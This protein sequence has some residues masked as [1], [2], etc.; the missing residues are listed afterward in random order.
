MQFCSRR[1][2][3]EH[4]DRRPPDRLLA[5][6]PCSRD[7]VWDPVYSLCLPETSAYVLGPAGIEQTLQP[8]THQRG[9]RPFAGEALLLDGQLFS[10]LLP[11]DLRVIAMP[12]RFAPGPY[13]RAYQEAFNAAHMRFRA[14]K[15]ATAAK[16][17]AIIVSTAR[18]CRH[19]R[20]SYHTNAKS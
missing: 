20:S 15:P 14:K 6:S 5:L 13:R 10:P 12:P 7:V 18:H 2:R 4:G 16:A 9:I 3:I 11:D 17:R 8:V 19:R 1:A